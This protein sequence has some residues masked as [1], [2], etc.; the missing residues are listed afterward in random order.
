MLIVTY[1]PWYEVCAIAVTRATQEKEGL[2]RRLKARPK[3]NL[4]GL[5][6]PV[7]NSK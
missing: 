1:R 2:G 5:I 7:L 3:A 6:L 4:H